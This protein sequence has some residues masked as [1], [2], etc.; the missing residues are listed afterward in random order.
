[1]S[2][3]ISIEKHFPFEI[4]YRFVGIQLELEGKRFEKQRIRQTNYVQP[5]RM[6][7][8]CR[9][10][11]LVLTLLFVLMIILWCVA[12]CSLFAVAFVNVIVVAVQLV[13]RQRIVCV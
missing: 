4:S 10:K 9:S 8:K 2:A 3:Q 7:E 6:F 11:Y 1:M 13:L 12:I 5:I